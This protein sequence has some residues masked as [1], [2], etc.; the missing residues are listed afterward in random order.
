MLKYMHGSGC[1]L[2]FIV[3]SLLCCDMLDQISQLAI[4]NY[5]CIRKGFICSDSKIDQKEKTPFIQL[6]YVDLQLSDSI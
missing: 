1:L 2:P 5:V 6:H 3:G 4:I